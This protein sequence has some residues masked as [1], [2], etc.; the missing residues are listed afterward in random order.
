MFIY[1]EGRR[2]SRGV[3]CAGRK[4]RG[5]PEDEKNEGAER[6]RTGGGRKK[7]GTR[8]DGGWC[9]V[10]AESAGAGAIN[11]AG[12]SELMNVIKIQPPAS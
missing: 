5:D 2:T 1:K 9:R 4:T 6:A 10:F 11:L 7:G 8:K 12:I 3:D